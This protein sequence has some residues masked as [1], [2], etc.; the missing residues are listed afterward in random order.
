[1]SSVV[2]STWKIIKPSKGSMRTLNK[3]RAITDKI[4]MNQIN[5]SKPYIPLSIGDP[6]YFGNLNPGEFVTSAVIKAIK[7]GKA[8]GYTHSCGLYSARDAIAKE[9]GCNGPYPLTGD[10]LFVFVLF[11]IKSSFGFL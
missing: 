7:E 10:V 8:N 3:I 11:F 9:Y 4:D 5:K 6:S 1:M 2:P